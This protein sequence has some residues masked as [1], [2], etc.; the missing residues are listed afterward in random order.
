MS[1]K[2]KK[3]AGEFRQFIAKG[4]VVDLAVA[5]VI[6]AAFNKIVSQ[7]VESFITPLLGLILKGLSLSEWKWV[8][9]E[10]QLDASGEVIQGEIAITHGLILQ[11]VIDFLLTALVVFVIVKVYNHHRRRVEEESKRIYDELNP[12]EAEAKRK[13]EEEA[14]REAERAEAEAKA[15][16]EAEAAETKA[17]EEAKI[18]YFK[19]QQELLTEIRDS[20]KK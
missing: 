3:L 20:L 19:T 12:E 8:L 17:R 1:N 2:N 14:K 11:A 6:G 13:A 18:E 5:M 9:K 7:I 10:E 4:N 15:K 16:A